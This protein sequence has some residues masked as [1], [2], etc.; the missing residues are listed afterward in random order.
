MAKIISK[1][2]QQSPQ[3]NFYVIPAQTFIL[4]WKLCDLFINKQMK[5]INKEVD[6][7]S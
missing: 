4:L 5:L 2:T 6:F 1:K 3:F 7:W